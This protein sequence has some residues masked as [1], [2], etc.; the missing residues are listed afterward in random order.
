MVAKNLPVGVMLLL[1]ASCFTAENA[2]QK[3][4]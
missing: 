3:V 1:L 2:R 4:G